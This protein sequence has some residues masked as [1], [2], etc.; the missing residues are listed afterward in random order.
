MLKTFVV[1]GVAVI[2]ATWVSTMLP[3]GK[4]VA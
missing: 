1:I 3:M 4:R 2:V